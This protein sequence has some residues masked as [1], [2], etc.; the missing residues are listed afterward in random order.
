MLDI[1][2][3]LYLPGNRFEVSDFHSSYDY[4][5]SKCSSHKMK[6]AFKSYL[7]FRQEM[8]GMSFAFMTVS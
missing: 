6:T 8:S 5:L 2:T 7:N 1:L 4:C 3:E